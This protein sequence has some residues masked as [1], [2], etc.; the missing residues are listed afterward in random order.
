MKSTPKR[1]RKPNS[2]QAWRSGA[3][4]ACLSRLCELLC[5]HPFSERAA[6]ESVF[7]VRTSW[8]SFDPKA[9]P[10]AWAKAPWSIEA[11]CGQ[12][13][14]DYVERA[15]LRHPMVAACRWGSV[16]SIGW[17]CAQPEAEP[18]VRF[19]EVSDFWSFNRAAVSG[20][21][22][23]FAPLWALAKGRGWSDR[24]FGSA[25]SAWLMGAQ[26]A[27]WDC[28]ACVGAARLG[29]H[30]LVSRDSNFKIPASPASTFECALSAAIDLDVH[31]E[32]DLPAFEHLLN[33]FPLDLWLHEAERGKGLDQ[34]GEVLRAVD[35]QTFPEDALS[36]GNIDALRRLAAVGALM[37]SRER[38]EEL[39]GGGAPP[40][41][42]QLAARSWLMSWR[43]EIECEEIARAVPMAPPAPP[44]S[45]VRAL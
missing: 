23:A 18:R 13:G 10:Q 16:E 21:A 15:A 41:P 19:S 36:A 17:L 32:R 44:G 3:G 31:H 9:D 35:S 37:P 30:E 40:E 14:N 28:C 8:A 24:E 39:L 29:V 2:A 27:D 42:G 11:D 7:H 45:S 20:I 12:A 26:E 43:A 5:E 22:G 38:E 6:A 4:R 1:L 34:A 33:W 25:V